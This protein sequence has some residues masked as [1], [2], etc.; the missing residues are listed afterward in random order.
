[1]QGDATEAFDSFPFMPPVYRTR[2]CGQE[3]IGRLIKAIA[4]GEKQGVRSTS[5]RS[6]L[7]FGADRSQSDLE[8]GEGGIGARPASRQSIT[9]RRSSEGILGCV[10]MQ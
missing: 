6:P 7:E 4:D 1:M 2:K 10:E 8:L 9:R 3:N 5:L